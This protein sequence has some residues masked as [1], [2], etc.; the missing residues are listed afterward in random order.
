MAD[1]LGREATLLDLA[2][3]EHLA[4]RQ[5]MNDL[6]R[7]SFTIVTSTLVAAAA[8][9]AAVGGGIFGTDLGSRGMLLL[10]IAAGMDG[11]GL[12]AVGVLNA[13]KIMELQIDK[14]ANAI[15]T[16]VL[17]EAPEAAAPFLSFQSDVRGFTHRAMGLKDRGA[18]AA[19]LSSYG[20]FA[21]MGG[22][23]VCL[24]LSLMALGAWLVLFESHNLTLAGYGALVFDVLLPVG[25]GLTSFISNMDEERWKGFFY[26]PQ[27]PPIGTTVS[28]ASPGKPKRR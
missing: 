1:R 15:R 24:T 22:L 5:E 8:A 23:V 17:T 25:L 3:R 18:L 12:W 28:A 27:E 21:V 14:T 9:S 11:I 10:A 26:G 19:W 13:C 7:Q 16:I 4:L 2:M 6:R 20:L